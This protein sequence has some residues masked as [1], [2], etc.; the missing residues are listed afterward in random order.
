MLLFFHSFSTK[1]INWA[2]LDCGG[3]NTKFGY[4]V[5]MPCWITDLAKFLLDSFSLREVWIKIS[6]YRRSWL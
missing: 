6:F 4:L 1:K 2:S 5:L 3:K